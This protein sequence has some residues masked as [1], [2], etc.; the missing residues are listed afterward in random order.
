M[1]SQVSGRALGELVE[2]NGT[3]IT[4]NLLNQSTFTDKDLMHLV[5][6][7]LKWRER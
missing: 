3:L 4:L 2:K 7:A 1:G 6:A 5:N